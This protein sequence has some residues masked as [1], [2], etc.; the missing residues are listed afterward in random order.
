MIEVTTQILG[1]R[2]RRDVALG[3][4]SPQCLRNDGGQIA[5][6]RRKPW[7]FGIDQ[8]PHGLRGSAGPAVPAEQQ[9]NQ[10]TRRIDIRRGRDSAARHLLGSGES[11]V[12]AKP[13]SRVSAVDSEGSSE[14]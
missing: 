3:G 13:P 6:H 9:I 8:R 4:L 5:S 7:K 2:R 10:H 11:G 14:S 12:R 1:E